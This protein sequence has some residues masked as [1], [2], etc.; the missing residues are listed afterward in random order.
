MH[1]TKRKNRTKP[2]GQS[3]QNVLHIQVIPVSGKMQPTPKS[4]KWLP[5]SAG[6]YNIS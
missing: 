3:Y 2:Y 5:E 4:N 1:S 6:F